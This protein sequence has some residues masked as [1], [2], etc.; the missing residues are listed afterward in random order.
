MTAQ[1]ACKSISPIAFCAALLIAG[2]R[3]LGSPAQLNSAADEQYIRRAEQEWVDVTLKSDADAFASFL[4][5]KYV[6]LTS[7]GRYNEKAGWAAR[8]RSGVT[9][10]DAVELKDLKVRFPTP[11]IA[12]VTGAFTQTGV[13]E[14]RSNSGA[15]FYINTWARVNGKWELVSSGFALPPVAP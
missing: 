10:Y 12:V 14:G 7:S 4:N 8:I 2:C 6:A 11:D 9:H 1:T 15:G 3:T 5:D 13:T